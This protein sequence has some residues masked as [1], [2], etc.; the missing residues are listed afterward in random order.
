M[1]KLEQFTHLLGNTTQYIVCLVYS[2]RE[3]KSIIFVS[4]TNS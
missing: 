1:M 4:L 3:T 2:I